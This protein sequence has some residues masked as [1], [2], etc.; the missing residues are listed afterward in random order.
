[1][2]TR[3]LAKIVI[4]VALMATV[5]SIAGQTAFAQSRINDKVSRN[6]GA[7]FWANNRTSRNIQH[8]RDYSH[9]IQRYT[10]QVPTITPAITQSESEMLGHQIHGIQR[11]MVIIREENA[12]TPQ[13][14][15]QVK[16]IETK[17]AQA[18]TTQKL[19]HEECC[20]DAPGGKICGEMAAKISGT[21]GQVSKEHAK[22]LKTL[23]QED[24]A[25]STA[26]PSEDGH[27]ASK[28]KQ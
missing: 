4:A 5:T 21:L 17:L 23:G 28:A 13:V 3:S 27:E 11:D 24:A 2:S 15:E 22:L 12:S 18:A 10:T 16:G 9:S 6:N 26:H 19:L 14:V 7:G 20:K 1:M 8:A 25:H